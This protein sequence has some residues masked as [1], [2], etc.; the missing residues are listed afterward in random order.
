MFCFC[1][2]FAFGFS[3]VFF[4]ISK[5][6]DCKDGSE[7]YSKHCKTFTLEFHL[8]YWTGFLIRLCV[9]NISTFT[10]KIT[11][12]YKYFY[13]GNISNYEKKSVGIKFELCRCFASIYWIYLDKYPILGCCMNHLLQWKLCWTWRKKSWTK[14]EGPTEWC[15]KIFSQVFQPVKYFTRRSDER[16]KINTMQ[17]IMH[18]KS[19][20]M[21]LYDCN[22]GLMM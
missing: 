1:F 16:D 10:F 14:S 6:L 18:M 19:T 3:A 22:I 12:I 4:K 9:L 7:A 13:I 20:D 15:E 2:A 8:V 21:F 17:I 5:I 11:S